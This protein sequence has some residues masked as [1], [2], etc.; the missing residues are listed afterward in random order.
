MNHFLTAFT[1]F[2]STARGASPH[3]V[4]AYKTDINAFITHLG[5]PTKIPSATPQNVEDFLAHLAKTHK[6][7]SRSLARKLSAIRQFYAFLIERNWAETDPTE[8]IKTP[9]QSK[10][11]PKALS[12]NQI[13]KL[14]NSPLQSGGNL[15]EMHPTQLRLLLILQ[16]LYAT[17]LRVSE[18]CQLTQDAVLEGEFLTLRVI[19]KG[20]KTRLVPLGTTAA[21][22]LQTYLHHA[23]PQ[24]RGHQG[25]WLF[26][27]PNGKLPLTRQRIFQLIQNAGESV[28]IKV[29]PHHLRHTFASHLVANDADLR[30]VQLMLGHASLNTTQ[31]YT[32]ITHNR[33][34]QT[35][36]KHHPLS[37]SKKK[38]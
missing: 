14:L 36:E 37:L 19:G 12:P 26:P 15:S 5:N 17:G 27:A 35:L 4:S 28:G 16:L 34:T 25:P 18:L 33:L 32:K 23:R 31:I 7:N 38:I 20:Q 29:A 8:S 1:E 2:L 30:S 10:P 6:L 22:T 21:A 24:L 13:E 11:L 3:T 9:K